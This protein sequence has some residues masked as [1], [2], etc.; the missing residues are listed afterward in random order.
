M[1]SEVDICNLALSN[2]GDEATV[3]SIDPAE[4]SA[5]AD[6]CA[7]FYPMARD[8]LLE[9]HAWPFAKSRVALAERVNPTRQWAYCYAAPA[10]LLRVLAVQ[11][12]DAPD[13]EVAFVI[14]ERLKPG[15]GSML[16]T[17]DPFDIESH[18]DD[19]ELVIYTN[20]PQAM[21]RYTRRMQDTTKF[22][23]LFTTALAALLSSKLAGSVVRGEAGRAAAR[24]WLNVAQR[25]VA[26]AALSAANQGTRRQRFTPKHLAAR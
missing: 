13:D 5:Q 6:R 19:G 24:D 18:P 25:Y 26:Q 14:D 12:V 11:S 8:E 16:A 17:T 1:S 21:V 20:T 4:G 2:L 23:P 10:N 7:T 9:T 15:L 3:T 22:S